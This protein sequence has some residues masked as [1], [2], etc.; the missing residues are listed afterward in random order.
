MVSSQCSVLSAHYSVLP[1][2]G[3]TFCG[4]DDGHIKQW[5]VS[6]EGDVSMS[7]EFLHGHTGVS[8]PSPRTKLLCLLASSL[9]LPISLLV[10]AVLACCVHWC[11]LLHARNPKAGSSHPEI[12][13]KGPCSGLYFWSPVSTS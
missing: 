12:P 5:S 4:G 6:G 7:R 2:D 10:S 1:D 9:V 3:T 8:L 11:S 13:K